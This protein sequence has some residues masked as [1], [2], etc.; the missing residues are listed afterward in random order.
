[1]ERR[2][3][4]YDEERSTPGGPEESQDPTAGDA[5]VRPGA[6]GPGPAD[7]PG[8]PPPTA[9]GVH[10]AGDPE[11][12][13]R[14]AERRT[15]EEADRRAAAR[16]EEDAREASREQRRHIIGRVTLG[17]DYLF[18]LLYGLL[19]VRFLLS[20][21]GAREG[22]GFV[23]FVTGMTAPFYAP[24]EGIVVR[25]PVNGGFIDFPLMIAVLAYAL[26][27]IAIRGLLRLIAGSARTP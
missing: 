12:E 7:G 3:Y 16:R 24:F 22:A 15:S 9:G 17:V 14:Q 25:P 11:M 13:R 10:D 26:L 4:G 8:A 27:H 18:Y 19:A 5:P 1:M 21:L 23:Q 2:Q 20:L 6:A